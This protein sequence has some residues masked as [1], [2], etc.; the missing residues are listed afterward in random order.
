[1]AES[2]EKLKSLLMRV[3]EENERIG[4]RPWHWA[5]YCM[6]NRRGKMEVVTDL[7]FLGAKITADG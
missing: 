2:E 4:L 3:K 6:A 7:L 5:H 1:M